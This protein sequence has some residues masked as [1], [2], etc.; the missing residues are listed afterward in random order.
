MHDRF[1]IIPRPVPTL[2]SEDINDVQIIADRLKRDEPALG[3][4]G[5][6]GNFVDQDIS[7]LPTIIIGDQ[8]EV[9]LY[10]TQLPTSLDYRMAVLARAGDIVVVH[11][12]N[13]AFEN[14]LKNYLKLAEIQFLEADAASQISSKPIS[15]A[16]RQHG[17]LRSPIESA[18]IKAG[19]MNLLAY[20]TTGNIWRL[21]SEIAAERQIP[22][23]I[24]GPTPRVS[25]RANNKIWFAN[26]VR[27]LIGFDSVSPSFAAFGPAA[28]AA[29]V[30]RLSKS[31]ERVV[32]KVP[33]SAG[34]LGN[35]TFVANE[36]RD[37]PLQSIRQ[38]LMNLLHGI[39]WQDKYPLQIGVWNCHVKTSPSAQ[40]WIPLVSDGA[41]VIE[42]IFEQVVQGEVGKFEGARPAQLSDT[43]RARFS[44][45]ALKIATLFQQLGYVGLCSLDA[46][47]SRTTQEPEL[48][49]WIECNGRWGGVSIPLTLRN[50]L[51]DDDA[52]GI[53]IVQQL[54]LDRLVT[55]TEQFLSVF[56]DVLFKSS[57]ATSG[58]ILLSPI[59]TAKGST[60]NFLA[61]GRDQAEADQLAGY[62]LSKIHDL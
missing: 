24:C 36:L 57:E 5:Y 50:G 16:C 38:R 26:L 60:I 46:I 33:D 8:Q 51:V 56:E 2:N 52:S 55:S 3:S 30:A 15:V 10:S 32:V 31:S 17:N 44:R 54:D 21:G 29:L 48:L 20:L 14:Y 61:I 42:G 1:P 28:A 58:V 25:Q 4:M 6:F 47:I 49:Q 13:M 18:A 37:I 22:V 41:P 34:S 11:Q 12:R 27:D 43:M 23:H 7:D 39:G 45:E 35:F 53:V 40:L 19:G 62:V 59:E 9:G